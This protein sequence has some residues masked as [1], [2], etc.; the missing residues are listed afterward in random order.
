MFRRLKR[1]ELD[2]CNHGYRIESL[3]A[4]ITQLQNRND[5]L[6]SQ[7]QKQRYMLS[8]LTDHLG[9]DIRFIEEHYKVVKKGGPEDVR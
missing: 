2:I 7:I 8:L 5:S 4:A 3:Q 1:A 6:E 9:V